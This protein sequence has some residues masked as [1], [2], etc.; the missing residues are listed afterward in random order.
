[1][2]EVSFASYILVLVPA[3]H[4]RAIVPGCVAGGGFRDHEQG[5]LIFHSGSVANEE[6][7][8]E[9]NHTLSINPFPGFAWI[10]RSRAVAVQLLSFFRT[11]TSRICHLYFAISPQT[12]MLSRLRLTTPLLARAQLS[13][14]RTSLFRRDLS[15]DLRSKLDKVRHQKEKQTSNTSNWSSMTTLGCTRQPG[16]RFYERQQRNSSMWIQSGCGTDSEFAG[17]WL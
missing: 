3:Y 16:P 15:D 11:A 5:N 6:G 17:G 14:V 2:G 12:K 7:D 8:G 1:M 9:K 4:D 10:G 13:H